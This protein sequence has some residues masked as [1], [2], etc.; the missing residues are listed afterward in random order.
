M[1]IH[2]LG[3]SPVPLAQLVCYGFKILYSIF[4]FKAFSTV[5]HKVLLE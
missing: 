2:D 4:Y 3:Q 5:C 1:L